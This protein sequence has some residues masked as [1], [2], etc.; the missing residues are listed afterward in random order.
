VNG[1]ADTTPLARRLPDDRDGVLRE[2]YGRLAPSL[3]VWASVRIPAGLRHRI[4]PADLMQ[5]VWWRAL[6][7]LSGFDPQ[8]GG[9]RGWLFGIATKTLAS[10]L[11][12]LH[13]RRGE[14]HAAG[15]SE[16]PDD[17]SEVVEQ[18]ARK[19]ELEQFIQRVRQLADE[20]RALLLARGL[21]GLPHAEVAARF[22]GTA[23]SVEIRWRRLRARLRLAIPGLLTGDQH[24]DA[25]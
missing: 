3:F 22:G 9:F 5:E 15:L 16:L 25:T 11:R 8:R 1:A 2:L 10:E 23:R 21:E 13:V 6:H 24:P 19:E 4:E 17:V 14:V 7:G 18:V 20:D 12:R